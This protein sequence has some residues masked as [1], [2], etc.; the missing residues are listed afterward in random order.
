MS[1]PD[2]VEQQGV[3]SSQ[4][5]REAYDQEDP[6]RTDTRLLATKIELFDA[7]HEPKLQT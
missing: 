2:D 4:N 1:K 6:Y 5:R 3:C 7:E